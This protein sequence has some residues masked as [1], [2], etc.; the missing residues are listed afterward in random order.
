MAGTRARRTVELRALL[1][2]PE[3]GLEGAG[4]EVQR[5]A[6]SLRPEKILIG[7]VSIVDVMDT[8]SQSTYDIV[9]F[10][11]HGGP[12][13]IV[14]GDDTL[15]PETL[16]QLLRQACP[17]LVV[18]N[19][20]TSVQTAN[21]LHDDI[22]CAVV[23]TIADVPDRDAYVTGTLLAS[24]LARGMSVADA[25]NVSKPGHNRTYVLLNGTVRMGGDDKLDDVQRLLL[26]LSAD[27]QRQ[28]GD[29]HGEVGKLREELGDLRGDVQSTNARIDSMG[30]RYATP[31]DRRRALGWLLAFV[32]F[33]V[34]L[35][36][37][38][39]RDV[40]HVPPVVAG[41]FAAFVLSVA[42]WLFVW[43]IGFR[44]SR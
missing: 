16:T 31:L 35:G 22:G 40:L 7:T 21:Q 13:G 24:A 23:A 19:T 29:M 38:D 37:W 32:L 28:L 41:L 6:N 39:T 34:G 27:L 42:A 2:A 25:Y 15:P 17:G 36:V 8:L 20:C 5:V 44:F 18:I 10:A 12:D 33:L 14:L 43:G 4:V 11:T 30:E 26:S 9:W 1:I 3:L